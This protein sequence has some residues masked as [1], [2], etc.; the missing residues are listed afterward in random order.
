MEARMSC[1]DFVHRKRLGISIMA[2]DK[3]VDVGSEGHDASIDL[4]SARDL[5]AGQSGK[6]PLDLIEPRGA[7]GRQVAARCRDQ[8]DP[9]SQ[10]QCLRRLAARG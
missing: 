9:C 5:F 10:R 7:C 2:G 3:G 6:E 1:A 4:D 8:R